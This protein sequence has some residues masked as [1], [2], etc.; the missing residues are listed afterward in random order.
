MYIKLVFPRLGRRLSATL[1]RIRGDFLLDNFPVST[2]SAIIIRP[3]LVPHLSARLAASILSALDETRVPVHPNDPVVESGPIYE[4]HRVLG[5][6]AH[7]VL[8]ETKTARRLPEL[9]EAHDDASDVAAAREELVYL[10]LRAEE[11][12]VADV[13]GAREFQEAILFATGT[14][15]K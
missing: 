13:E 10:L 8:D 11:G 4:T 14:L 9:V 5:I 3:V 1:V 7:V 6:V 2:A 12:Q 15:K